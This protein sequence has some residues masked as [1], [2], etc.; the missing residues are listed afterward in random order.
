MENKDFSSYTIENFAAD[1]SFLNYCF[2]NNASDVEFWENWISNHPEKAAEI[3][4][5]RKLVDALS[6][7]LPEQEYQQE[8]RRIKS[9]ISSRQATGRLTVEGKQRSMPAAT[10]KRRPHYLKIAASM[11]VLLVAGYL[12]TA[13]LPESTP[14]EIVYIE[15]IN[16]P[17]QKST[18]F[19]KD[20][21]KV[22]L[23]SASRLRFPEDFGTNQ[24]TLELEGEAFFE[25]AKDTTPFTVTAAGI[26]TTAL[27]TSF[28]IRAFPA[29]ARMNVALV[30]GKV[31]VSGVAA[32]AQGDT[33]SAFLIPGEQV[34]YRK[35]GQAFEKG[36]FLAREM[37]G[38]KDGVIYFNDTPFGEV[39][40]TMERWYGV[41][42]E[43]TGRKDRAAGF[44]GEFHNE[45]LE[46]IL[47]AMSYS[48]KFQY[49]INKRNV[50]LEFTK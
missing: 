46:N 26:R 27:G 31:N 23:N 36:Q 49:E 8:Y 32:G 16:P 21:S 10:R 43:I 47:E 2:N 44:S 20:G 35:G 11:L 4:S 30:T 13:Y 24:R 6:L 39:I 42:F 29:D 19:L 18:I 17:G 22:I 41:S 9:A 50:L 7:K 28:N 40:E 48:Q 1:E 37:L 33:L 3:A 5:A 14:R 34:I 45:S 15:K 38:W 25:V 12:I